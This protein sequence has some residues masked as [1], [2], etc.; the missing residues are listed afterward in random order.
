M[1]WG[2]LG[3]AAPWNILAQAWNLPLGPGHQ[4]LAL[5]HALLGTLPHWSWARGGGKG[6]QIRWLKS[7]LG[8]FSSCAS[9][10]IRIKATLEGLL[11]TCTLQGRLRAAQNK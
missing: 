6:W 10:T 1:G 7:W 3:G 8:Y 2:S 9:C 11:L 5:I 4:G